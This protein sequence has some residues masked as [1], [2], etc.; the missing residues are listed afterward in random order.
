MV[1]QCSGA[2]RS[3]CWLGCDGTS[4][5]AW[6]WSLPSPRV[7]LVV[8]SSLHLKRFTQENVLAW[9]VQTTW[10]SVSISSG[11]RLGWCGN[12]LVKSPELKSR[13]CNVTSEQAQ[14]CLCARGCRVI[15]SL[16]PCHCCDS[17]A[18]LT[19][20]ALSR[21]LINTCCY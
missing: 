12:S 21:P 17:G 3:L 2:S 16:I 14:A 4:V 6:L 9:A 7:L 11:D 15:K 18:R 13:F 1:A 8:P 19:E 10:L 20:P 5:L